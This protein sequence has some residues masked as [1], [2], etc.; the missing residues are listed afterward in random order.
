[1]WRS[2][3]AYLP[4]VEVVAGSN[5][6]ILT[7]QAQ[8]SVGKITLRV[9]PTCWRTPKCRSGITPGRGSLNPSQLKCVVRQPPRDCEGASDGLSENLEHARSI[10]LYPVAG[11]Q[12]PPTGP[13][14]VV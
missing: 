9:W 11:S 6:A 8:C 2:L 3:V 14:G 10:M 13:R 1:M 5:P 12:Q 7:Q 4:G